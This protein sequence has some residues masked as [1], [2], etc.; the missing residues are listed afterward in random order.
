[1]FLT[2]LNTPKM[3]KFAEEVNSLYIPGM[4]TENVGPFLFNL[5]RSVRAKTVV[6]VGTGYTSPFIVRA[7]K[8]N[9]DDFYRTKNS[10][11][12]K[13]KKKFPE[14]R[15]I[16]HALRWFGNINPQFYKG[17]FNT[18]YFG[19]D[20]ISTDGSANR[21]AQVIKKL[22]L[23]KNTNFFEGDFR[24]ELSK[25]DRKT[26]PIDLI[27]MD[28][29]NPLIEDFDLLRMTWRHLNSNG[30]LFVSHELPV[31]AVMKFLHKDIKLK[32]F[33]DYEI[34]DF[35]E[36]HKVFQNSITIIKKVTKKRTSISGRKHVLN[37]A[38]LLEEI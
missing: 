15:D 27:F 31:E 33:K 10:I 37:L 16:R 29:G 12:K 2:D 11:K 38:S 23:E 3:A 7:L 24:T 36:T 25:V 8:E 4:G 17:D 18:A 35:R 9:K 6:E 32:P 1:M 20:D 13:M 26:F 21:A 19:I 5:I 34:I 28:A 30:G 14:F 22:G